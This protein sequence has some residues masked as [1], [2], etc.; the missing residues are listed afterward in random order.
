[1]NRFLPEITKYSLKIWN[2]VLFQLN[3]YILIMNMLFSFYENKGI[4]IMTLGPKSFLSQVLCVCVLVCVCV[5]WRQLNSQVSLIC[6]YN[7]LS[8]SCVS[9]KIC[10]KSKYL[11]NQAREF[12]KLNISP[13]VVLWIATFR[14]WLPGRIL[15][16][17]LVL[18]NCLTLF[19]LK[20]ARKGGI[21]SIALR[22]QYLNN[23]TLWLISNRM[24][25]VR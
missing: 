22:L 1:M 3:G 11:E 24:T 12:Y 18:N 23:L 9:S 16:I 14:L 4:N 5:V 25:S 2:L 10:K 20:G 8:K 15:Q 13:K 6:A 17:A 21:A 19:Y 7:F